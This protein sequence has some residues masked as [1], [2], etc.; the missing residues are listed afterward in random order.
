MQFRP[1]RHDTEFCRC[2]VFTLVWFFPL[3]M[4]IIV[5]VIRWIN[6][7]QIVLLNDPNLKDFIFDE[8]N[9]DKFTILNHLIKNNNMFSYS[10]AKFDTIDCHSNIVMCHSNSDCLKKCDKKGANETL[11]CSSANN[12]VV[13]NVDGKCA[14]SGGKWIYDSMTKQWQCVQLYPNYFESILS[15]GLR[16]KHNYVCTNGILDD[17]HDVSKLPFLCTCAGVDKVFF[18]SN[19]NSYLP[20][21]LNKNLEKF[22]TNSGNYISISI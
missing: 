6:K 19:N 9:N 13:K 4:L 7:K 8:D 1:D 14:K 5:I 3:A 21:C 11:R 12:C 17:N 16:D 10:L 20:L 22:Y 18:Q 15:S 2:N